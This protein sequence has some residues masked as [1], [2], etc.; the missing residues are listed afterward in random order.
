M[1]GGNFTYPQTECNPR[2]QT[3]DGMNS[4]Y[5]G[6]EARQA[7]AIADALNQE[8]LTVNV[9]GT[10]PQG[11]YFEINTTVGTTNTEILTANND[12]TYLVIHNLSVAHLYVRFGSAAAEGVGHLV[13]PNS[14]LISQIPQQVSQ[15]VNIIAS[16]NSSEI[17]GYYIQ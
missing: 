6:K 16:E 11:N 2:L 9:P 14:V 10:L 5:G 17:F 15:S 1:A 8:G 3:L 4:E 13:C 7:M 12:R